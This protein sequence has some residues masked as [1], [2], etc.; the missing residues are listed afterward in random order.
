MN[1]ADTI[2]KILALK[3]EVFESFIDIKKSK[4]DLNRGLSLKIFDIPIIDENYNS[5]HLFDIK[6]QK[7]IFEI[8]GQINRLNEEIE[9][10]RFYFQ[11]TFDSSLS[12]KNAEIVKTN[13]EQSYRNINRALINI[14]NHIGAISGCNLTT[15]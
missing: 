9:N 13:L 14:S 15:G 5:L 2:E 8:R 12:D 3:E 7:D 6:F 11:K 4:I 1:M 10:A